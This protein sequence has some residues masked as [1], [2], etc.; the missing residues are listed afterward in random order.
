MP[1]PMGS[2][3]T[4]APSRNN[5]SSNNDNDRHKHDNTYNTNDNHNNKA[6]EL[7]CY[8]K[9]KPSAATPELEAR[10]SELLE[11]QQYD[12]IMM[13][14]IVISII[15]VI[16]IVIAIL[17]VISMIIIVISIVI[18]IL[19]VIGIISSN[20]SVVAMGG[21]GSIQRNYVH[22]SRSKMSM[23]IVQDIF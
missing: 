23:C 15:L 16:S 1:R 14:I 6:R 8:K 4:S 11:Y 9:A 13:I 10:S 20:T 5:I 7:K 18:A 12:T 3:A 22:P 21:S 19:L 2:S 17:L